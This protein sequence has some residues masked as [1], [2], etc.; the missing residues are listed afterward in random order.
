M[1][2]LKLTNIVKD[3]RTGDTVTHALKGVSLE[4]RQSE[5]VS[6]LG[7]S[8]CGKTTLLNIIGG[9]DRYNGGDLIINGLS[10]KD[11][12]DRDWDAYRNRSIGFVFQNYNLISHQTILQNVEISMTLS[13]VS[14]RERTR[15]AKEALEAVG[16]GDQIKKK[17]NQLS[18]GQ[19]QRVAIARALVNNPDII[20]ADEPTGALDSHT[21]VQIMEILKVISKTRLVIMVTHNGE[22]AEQYSSR[23]IRFL[24][25]EMK[26]DTNPI[27]EEE[28]KSKPDKAVVADKKM[29]KKTSMSMKTAIG[30]SFKNLLTKKGRT[31]ITAFAGSIGI[32]GVALVLALSN[33]LSS[34]IDN[35]QSDALAGFPITISTVE[36]DYSDQDKIVINGNEKADG[37]KK[38]PTGDEVYRYDKNKNKKMHKN[39][40][41]TD[42]LNYVEKMKT[43]LPDAVNT[44]SYARGVEINLLAKG[45]NSVVKYDTNESMTMTGMDSVS[46]TSGYWQEMPDNKDFILSQYDLIGEGS[47]LPTQKDEIAIVVDEYNR[48]D[49]QML[50]KLGFTTKTDKYKLTDFI[51]KTM[52]KVIPNNDFYKKDASGV[53][54]PVSTADYEKLYNGTNGVSLKITGILRKKD[55]APSEY[56][57]KGFIYTTALTD[58]IV[59][60]AN[61]SDVAQAQLNSNKDVILSTTFENDKAKQ[62]RLLSLGSVT[63]PTGINI[64]PKNFD[65][66]DKIK[67][68]LDNYN[69]NKDEK[70]KVIYSD[71]AETF[72]KMI[73]KLLDTVTMVLV[74]FAAVSL[75]VSTIMIGIITYVSVLERTKEIGILRS[76]GARK[77]D[78]SRVF[79]AETLIVGFVAGVLGVGISYLLTIPINAVINNAVKINNIANLAITSAGA[80]IVGSMILTL[81]AGL[82]PSRMAAKKD[83]V[84]ALRTD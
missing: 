13:G 49:D 74:G 39:V 70:Q 57:E 37:F 83:P 19:M 63:T 15:R 67:E 80:L 16:L 4:F 65:S 23:I 20:L 66:K 43:E 52:L 76:V 60:N 77:K 31:I 30:L 51:N 18:G 2:K 11:F 62:E 10:T 3:Y 6:I 21:S 73:G 64:Y 53:Y 44:I 41:S 48:I 32:I 22:M 40:L 69:K 17:P 61:K 36:Q 81:I 12:K 56:F 1:S 78:I 26:S 5:L 46:Y 27:T 34:Y 14:P 84:V 24:D 25:G 8:G 71:M 47:R 50:K 75:L 38:N 35:L 33:G 58:Y 68:Y 9:L 45:E 79:N 59:D 29:L 55:S 72:T 7:P 28:N 42:Y 82:I 54:A